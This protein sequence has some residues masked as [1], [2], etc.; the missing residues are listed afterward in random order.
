MKKRDDLM[1]TIL[2]IGCIANGA[3][4]RC[5][6]DGCFNPAMTDRGLDICAECLNEQDDSLLYDPFDWPD[7]EDE[8]SKQEKIEELH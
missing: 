7:E 3:Q 2:N 1:Q 6:I 8:M 4:L 5:R